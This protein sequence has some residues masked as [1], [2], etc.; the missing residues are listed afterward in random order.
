MSLKMYIWI[1]VGFALC[2]GLTALVVKNLAPQINRMSFATVNSF[3]RSTQQKVALLSDLHVGES[4]DELERLNLLWSQVLA[5]QPDIILLAGDY[6]KDTRYMRDVDA[7]RR[8][9]TE[10]LGESKNIPVVA[11]L[12]NH[13]TWSSPLLW[14]SAFRHFGK[15]GLVY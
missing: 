9:I 4:R 1:L 15:R 10:I 5:E 6:T 3:S 8:A 7:H 13:E 11:V 14:S 2:A 12:G